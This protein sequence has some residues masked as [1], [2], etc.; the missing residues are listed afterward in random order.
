MSPWWRGAPHEEEGGLGKPVSFTCEPEWQSGG[1]EPEARLMVAL[2]AWWALL[3]QDL[4]E[5]VWRG[6]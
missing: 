6:L 1:M 3:N 5:E 2:A 4:G